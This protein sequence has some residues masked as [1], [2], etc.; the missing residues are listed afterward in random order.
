MKAKA[1][2]T[3][4]MTISN[5]GKLDDAVKEKILEA[6]DGMV[7]VFRKR[8]IDPDTNT[9]VVIT[10]KARLSK[11]GKDGRGPKSLTSYIAFKLDGVESLLIGETTKKDN[12]EINVDD[13]ASSLGLE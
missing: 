1:Q 7:R 10:G 11:G 3:G 12:D 4:H 8:L 13:L 5:S 6:P 9:E 2:I